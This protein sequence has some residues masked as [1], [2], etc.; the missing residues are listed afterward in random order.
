MKFQFV[1][2]ILT[3]IRPC[4]QVPELALYLHASRGEDV[5]VTVTLEKWHSIRTCQ[6]ENVG[7]A[8]TSKKWDLA[9]GLNATQDKHQR[10]VFQDNGR[11]NNVLRKRG[12]DVALHD[13]DDKFAES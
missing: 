13:I 8:I 7:T 6:T 12:A 9:Q 1:L 10:K 11:R 2:T 3:Y 5:N 4:A